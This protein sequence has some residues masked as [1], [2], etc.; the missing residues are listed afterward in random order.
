M[1]LTLFFILY[2]KFPPHPSIAIVDFISSK[3]QDYDFSIQSLIL[4]MKINKSEKLLFFLKMGFLGR[5]GEKWM[6]YES[7]N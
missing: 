6:V 3:T 2:T 5:K 1:Q 7:G 4:D